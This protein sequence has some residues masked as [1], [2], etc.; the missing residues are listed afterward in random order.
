MA[1]QPRGEASA[2]DHQRRDRGERE[3]EGRLGG[4]P[5]IAQAQQQ[6]R[7]C[8]RAP[9]VRAPHQRHGA[10]SE[11]AHRQRAQGR[12]GAAAQER[13]GR[14]RQNRRQGGPAHHQAAQREP[15]ATGHHP[16]QR[17][18]RRRRD[19]GDVQPRH[20]Q[21]VRRPGTRVRSAQLRRDRA[22]VTIDECG[23]HAA[24]C[25]GGHR[26]GQRL[27]DR[28]A[29]L[30]ESNPD[31]R[32]T[33]GPG[34]GPDGAIVRHRR[35]RDH[36]LPPRRAGIPVPAP[37]CR[38]RAEP[39]SSYAP[40]SGHLPS[41]S[42]A[43]FQI[44]S[45]TVSPR[46]KPGAAAV[47]QMSSETPAVPP[48]ARCGRTAITR[49]R[50]SAARSGSSA[51]RATR[52]RSWCHAC[53]APESGGGRREGRRRPE[54]AVHVQERRGC[55]TGGDR[56]QHR[57]AAEVAQRLPEHGAERAGRQPPP[58][59]QRPK[60]RKSAPDGQPARST[61]IAS[62]VKRS[63]DSAPLSS[64]AASRAGQSVASLVRALLMRSASARPNPGSFSISSTAAARTRARLPK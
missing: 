45:R 7:S 48:R 53:N 10:E 6:G 59:R 23:Q 31:V 46:A 33:D 2:R 20:R 60:S 29:N 41:H 49:P 40:R 13:I 15:A 51:E 56:E 5:G 44:A 28:A 25:D 32:G 8:Q 1:A 30:G 57:P 64:R 18:E 22:L 17:A 27:R 24:R 34:D 4:N 58:P 35:D 37:G 52:A 50:S 63:G 47:K 55:R 16:A 54:S 39:A 14:R 11:G 42:R 9:H 26:V 38:S 21:H 43:V 36:P 62:R 3:L 12:D 61:S 19:H